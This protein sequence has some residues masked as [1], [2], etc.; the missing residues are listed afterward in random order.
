MRRRLGWRCGAWWLLEAVTNDKPS[1][2][3]KRCCGVRSE[4]DAGDPPATGARE[5]RAAVRVV[6]RRQAQSSCR[7]YNRQ[8][9]S[10]PPWRYLRCAA[11]IRPAPR[12]Y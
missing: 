5:G 2:R 7:N 1:R 6:L 10:R 12:S 4:P 8:C 11:A 9:R 3:F